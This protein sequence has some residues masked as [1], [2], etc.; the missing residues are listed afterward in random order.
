[1]KNTNLKNVLFLAPGYQYAMTVI[2]NL[3]RTLDQKGVPYNASKNS[4][5]MYIS[6][7]NV[8]VELSYSDPVKW[9][10]DLFRGRE[11]VFGKKELTDLAHQ[12]FFSVLISRPRVSLQK[13]ILYCYSNGQ[14]AHDHPTPTAYIPEIKTVH[15]NPPMTVV[16]WTDGTK[17]L[18]KCQDGDIYSKETGLALCIAKKAL[19]NMPNFNNVF[20]KWIPEEEG[21]DIPNI[22]AVYQ[23]EEFGKLVESRID[24]ILKRFR[25][26][27]ERDK[28]GDK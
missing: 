21:I 15:F 25:E 3:S 13:Y 18:V 26:K 24:R 11:A 10:E 20:K 2:D 27:D 16:L 5:N 17:T 4:K 8:H 19:G 9:T 6:T 12:K 22:P 28:K 14:V 23:S 1:M 7:E